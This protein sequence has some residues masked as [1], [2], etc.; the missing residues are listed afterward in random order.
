[1]CA[2]QKW[3]VRGGWLLPAAVDVSAILLS[4]CYGGRAE[5]GMKNLANG[6]LATIEAPRWQSPILVKVS[7]LADEESASV[8]K[9]GRRETQSS[10]WAFT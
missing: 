6:I 4:P 7:V 8:F 5:R 3:D 9:L 2:P 1:M 10:I